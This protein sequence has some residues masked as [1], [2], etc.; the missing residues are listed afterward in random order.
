MGVTLSEGGGVTS[1]GDMLLTTTTLLSQR[2]P[3]SPLWRGLY[4]EIR[5]GRGLAWI[6]RVLCGKA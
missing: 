5:I 4:L 3:P 6:P 1:K 2:A